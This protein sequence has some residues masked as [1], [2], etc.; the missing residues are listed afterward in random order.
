MDRAFRTFFDLA[1]Y[2]GCFVLGLPRF[3]VVLSDRRIDVVVGT[4]PLC[5]LFVYILFHLFY[6]YLSFTGRLILIGKLLFPINYYI[7]V[8]R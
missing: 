1:Y 4:D 8:T 5:G 2:I 6:Y 3:E 7:S